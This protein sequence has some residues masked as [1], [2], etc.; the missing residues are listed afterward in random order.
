MSV[1]RKKVG[2]VWRLNRYSYPLQ[3]GVYTIADIS[4]TDQ[5]GYGSATVVGAD[6]RQRNIERRGMT[7][8]RNKWT[9]IGMSTDDPRPWVITCQSCGAKDVVMSNI[10]PGRG[11]CNV[12]GGRTRL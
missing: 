1:I 4:P 8:S 12:C 11:T 5:W 9:Y 6:G 10:P 3:P 2:Q 7:T